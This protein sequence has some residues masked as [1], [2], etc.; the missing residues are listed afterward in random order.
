MTVSYLVRLL[1]ARVLLYTPW[2]TDMSAPVSPLATSRHTFYIAMLFT[3]WVLMVGL[4]FWLLQQV[5]M[6]TD[7]HA[8]ELPTRASLVGACIAILAGCGVGSGWRLYRLARANHSTVQM[9]RDREA[10]FRNLV[11]DSVQGILI[12]RHCRPLFIN[13]AYADIFGYASPEALLHAPDIVSA[14]VAPHEQAALRRRAQDRLRGA[15]HPTYYEY[16][17]V[18]QDGQGVWLANAVRVVTWDGAPAI[19]STVVD[20][21]ARKHAEEKLKKWRALLHIGR[22][23]T[24]TLAAEHTP[25]QVLPETSPSRLPLHPIHDQPRLAALRQIELLDQSAVPLF[26]HLTEMACRWLPA[27]VALISL[28]DW[29][30][31]FFCSQHGLPAPWTAKRQTPLSHS[32]CQH[33]VTGATPLV[34]QDART[35]ARFVDHP[36]ID[37]LGVVAYLGTPLQTPNGEVIG[38]MCA[39]DDQARHWTEEDLAILQDLAAVAMQEIERQWHQQQSQ[40]ASTALR[41]SEARFRNMVEA[42]PTL[43]WMA[44]ANNHRTYCNRQ[45]LAFTGRTLSEELG[46]GWTQGI[47]PDDREHCLTTHQ[48]AFKAR[49]PCCL[50]Y[51]LRRWDG[52]Y[53]WILSHGTPQ[54]QADGVFAGYMGSCVD[55]TP[56]I[57][58]Q[59]LLAQSRDALEQQVIARTATLRQTNASLRRVIAE[60]D[61]LERHVLSMTKREQR[62]L[63]QELHDGLCQA[64]AGLTFLSQSIETALQK[65]EHPAAMKQMQLTQALKDVIKQARNLAKGFYPT[66][67]ETDGLEAAL[68]ILAA[69]TETVYGLG[70]TLVIDPDWVSPHPAIRLQLYRIVQ[71]AIINTV[72]HARAKT[73]SSGCIATP[74]V[75]CSARQTMARAQHG[76]RWPGIA[77]YLVAFDGDGPANHTLPRPDHWCRLDN[78]QPHGRWDRGGMSPPF[79]R[80]RF[81]N[82]M[83]GSIPCPPSPLS[84]RYRENTGFSSL[85]TISWFAP[86]SPPSSMRSRIYRSM[87]KRR[88]PPAP[89]TCS[90]AWS[91]TSPLLIWVS[92]IALASI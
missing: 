60:R 65:Q 35:H 61:Q 85:K 78:L 59:T 67:L 39:I 53:R 31:Q 83:L 32:F 9:L 76:R 84:T 89:K 4:C 23:E 57:E 22:W 92:K 62:R 52:A 66:E 40:A 28:V 77:L 26:D 1:T 12:H 71:E 46:Q 58:A 47:H 44:G 33:V 27:P 19:Q 30:R 79:A 14:V 21:T 54:F 51:R 25:S 6:E 48:I 7:R 20:I 5:V 55:I 81:P 8:A 45:W 86:D 15:E 70:V 80:R 37:D 87:Q 13:Q 82:R 73:C 64:L 43:I 17:G 42:S 56:Q 69:H 63:G 68:S 36:A 3:I 18:R 16:Q 74:P 50:S 41:E 29:N 75:S 88:T 2:Q 11:E 10:R 72:K 49:Q 90:L 38:A 24:A 91:W 34:V